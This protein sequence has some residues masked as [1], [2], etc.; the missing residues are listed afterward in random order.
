MGC[1]VFLAALSFFLP[2]EQVSAR[3]NVSLLI[4][5]TTVAYRYSV[6]SM[7]PS[8]AYVTLLDKYVFYCTSFVFA[9]VVENGTVYSTGVTVAQEHSFA[10]LLMALYVLGHAAFAPTVMRAMYERVAAAEE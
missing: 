6:M 5:L 10:K 8:I 9:I 1:F 2:M 7:M 4:V 3:L